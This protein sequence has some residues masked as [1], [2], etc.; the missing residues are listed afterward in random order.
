MGK[1]GSALRP[2]DRCADNYENFRYY[3]EQMQDNVSG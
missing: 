2:A 3:F 1:G